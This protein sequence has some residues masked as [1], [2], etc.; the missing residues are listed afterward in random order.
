MLQFKDV[1]GKKN[2]LVKLWIVTKEEPTADQRTFCKEKG[3]EILSISEFR[4]RIIDASQYLE[5]RNSHPFGSATNPEND[6]SDVSKIIYQPVGIRHQESGANLTFTDIA[7]LLGDNRQVLLLGDYGMGKSLTIS[8]IYRDL[9]IKCF[10]TNGASPVPVVLNLREHWGQCDPSE[11]L[12]RH[13]QLI[14]FTQPPQLVRAFNAGRIAVLLDGF[15]EVGAM[16]WTRL[17]VDQLRNLRRHA[18]QLVAR[19]VERSRGKCGLLVAGR[20]HFFDNTQELMSALGLEQDCTILGLDEFSETEARQYLEKLGCKH[21]LPEWLPKR[22]LLLASLASRGLLDAVL[23]AAADIEPAVAWNKL[24]DLIC[25][26]EAAIHNFLDAIGIRKILEYI[27]AVARE[28]M[29]GLG[30]ITEDH[31]AEAFRAQVGAYPDETARPLL[32]RLPGLSIR[33]QQDGTRTFLDDQM[34]DVLRAGAIVKFID[35]PWLDPNAKNWKHGIGP[36]GAMVAAECSRS[37]SH[38]QES[39]ILLATREACS[40]WAAPTL[41][42]DLIHVVRAITPEEDY[43]NFGNLKIEGGDCVSL[44]LS[45][46]PF[47]K[48]IVLSSCIISELILPEQN[49]DAFRI[50]NSIIERIIGCSEQEF[51][52]HWLASSEVRTFDEFC[53]NAQIMEEKRLRLPVRVMLTVLRK[54]YYQK[55][56]GRKE[57]ALFRGL[58]Q[59]ARKFVEPVMEILTREKAAF[60]IRNRSIRIWHTVAGQRRRVFEIISTANRSVRIPVKSTTHSEIC[61]PVIPEII[62]HTFRS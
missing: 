20:K 46:P 51:L 25:K 35:D 36:L 33:N 43:I 42:M 3:I 44:D 58:D 27:A 38:V 16:P 59:G 12:L 54:L 17:P 48:S 31:I 47:L 37:S 23:E 62:D 39:R 50:D 55:G 14:G 6:S 24:L 32:Q 11:A 18:V 15:D 52:P 8:Q 13:S 7:N 57:N 45:N 34:M 56:H 40:R 53:T 9:R 2:C 41:A 22:P 28:T 10:K 4:R 30:P 29:S 61:R 1:M 60:S 26:R 5:I 21:E 49:P 19:F